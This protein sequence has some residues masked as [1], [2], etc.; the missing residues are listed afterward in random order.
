MRIYS[1]SVR[2]SPRII[3]N[4]KRVLAGVNNWRVAFDGEA[5]ICSQSNPQF[6][7]YISSG[8]FSS[9]FDS[10][11][12]EDLPGHRRKEGKL[13]HAVQSSVSL[14]ISYIGVRAYR[15]WNW[16][17]NRRTHVSDVRISG[18]YKIDARLRLSYIGWTW[19][20]AFLYVVG[21]LWL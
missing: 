10:P 17:A 3:Y 21:D 18:G 4:R 20:L 9:F 16:C 8:R 15:I 12:G 14:L 2:L 7:L 13:R 11:E 19:T 5:A 1:N 6:S